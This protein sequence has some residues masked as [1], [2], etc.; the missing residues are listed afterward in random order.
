DRR[1]HDA[2]PAPAADAAAGD[3]AAGPAPD[4]AAHERR[5]R[6]VDQ[7]HGHPVGGGHYRADAPGRGVHGHLPQHVAAHLCPDRPDLFHIL[8]PVAALGQLGRKTLALLAGVVFTVLGAV[9]PSLLI[10]AIMSSDYLDP[11]DERTLGDA[12]PR[13]GPL[14]GP[15][16]TDIFAVGGGLA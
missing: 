3:P 12:L 14:S 7:E 10:S 4:R 9:H 6:H 16:D 15:A 13:H 11:F 1:G 8:L 5:L 2:G